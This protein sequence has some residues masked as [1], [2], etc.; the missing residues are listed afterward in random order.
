MAASTQGADRGTWR[1]RSRG[2][3]GTGWVV[4]ASEPGLATV[5]PNGWDTRLYWQWIG[6]NTIAFVIVLTV[7]FVLAV[8]GSDA[9]SLNLV[10]HHVVVALV[11]ATLGAA[12]FGGVLGALQWL[13]VRRRV[14][15]PRKVH[16]RVVTRT[17]GAS[18]READ[19]ITRTSDTDSNGM[20]TKG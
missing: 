12:L 5:S 20:N 3:H 6:Y 13:V 15:I 9:L 18:G 2:R 19:V 11:I 1:P 8:V 17:S 10:S 7:G 16:L 14:R 4:A